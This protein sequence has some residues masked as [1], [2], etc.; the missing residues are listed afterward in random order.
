MGGAS[1]GTAGNN[2][3]KLTSSPAFVPPKYALGSN[4]PSISSAEN[5]DEFSGLG[6][7]PSLAGGPPTSAP[8]ASTPAVPTPGALVVASLTPACPTTA[9]LVPSAVVLVLVASVAP[10]VGRRVLSNSTAAL[11][12]PGPCGSSASIFKLWNIFFKAA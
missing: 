6:C 7:D 1:V 11:T 8:V 4:L 10:I 3:S 5:P 12:A 9:A 2:L